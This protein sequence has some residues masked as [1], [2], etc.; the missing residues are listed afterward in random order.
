MN[1]ET[2]YGQN[3]RFSFVVPQKSAQ[4]LATLDASRNAIRNILGKQQNVASP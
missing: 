4:P 1:T 3:N 2:P